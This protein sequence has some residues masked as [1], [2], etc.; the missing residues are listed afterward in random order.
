M[1]CT[2]IV[3]FCFC[4]TFKTIFVHK[5]VVNLYFLGNSMNN[6]SSCFGVT[7]SRMRASEENLPVPNFHDI[8]TA[9]IIL[10][11]KIYKYINMIL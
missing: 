6:L 5:H 10:I 9:K 3:S 1:L 7:D 8:F 4:L 11:K 2:K